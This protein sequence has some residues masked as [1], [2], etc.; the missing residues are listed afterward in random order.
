MPGEAGAGAG[1]EARRWLERPPRVQSN[2]RSDLEECV[3]I[4]ATQ[5]TTR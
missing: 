4:D 2:E 3:W 1:T 5:Y